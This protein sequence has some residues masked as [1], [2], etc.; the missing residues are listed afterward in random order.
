MTYG[1]PEEFSSD[2][3]P[4]FVSAEFREFCAT[5]GI[6]QRISSAYFPHS[7]TRAEVAVKTVKR[8]IRDNLGNDGGLNGVDF[9]RSLLEYRNTPDRDTGR[10]PAQVLYGRQMRDFI[11]VAPGKYKPRAEWL[12]TMDQREKAL[13]KRHL[14]KGL[15]LAQGTKDHVPLV[16]GTVVMVQ[17]QVG[18]SALKWDKSGVVVADRGNS[19]YLV[20]L[21]GSGRTTLRNRAFLKR[22]TPFRGRLEL[23][24]ANNQELQR[25]VFTPTKALTKEAGVV[26]DRGVAHEEV[27]AEPGPVDDEG[28]EVALESQ[29]ETAR[30]EVQ[31]GVRCPAGR[32]SQRVVW[33]PTKYTE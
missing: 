26:L 3:G 11:P 30:E 13:A 16:P 31:L 17:N 18:K 12:L 29:G 4:Q 20:K 5:W 27:G 2:G 28:R 9:A 32:R 7:N 22:V 33:R 25:K 8:M 15:E 21:D 14:A 1:V 24:S 6:R 10:S 19:Q 23:D